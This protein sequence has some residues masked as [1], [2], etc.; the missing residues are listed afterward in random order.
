MPWMILSCPIIPFIINHLSPIWDSTCNLLRVIWCFPTYIEFK[1]F[2]YLNDIVH[3]GIHYT[4]T[5][6]HLTFIQAVENDLSILSKES[7]PLF[8]I[9]V[10][11][12][13]SYCLSNHPPTCPSSSPL[14][15]WVSVLLYMYRTCSSGLVSIPILFCLNKW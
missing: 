6:M 13:R 3:T 15:W 14:T 9:C 5:G 11:C 2:Q 4:S 7:T 8:N 10:K 1:A 12:G